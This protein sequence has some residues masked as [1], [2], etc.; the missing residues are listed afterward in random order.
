LGISP[1]LWKTRAGWGGW[2]AY[3]RATPSLRHAILPSAFFI[4]IVAE[5]SS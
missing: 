4:L 3:G 2:R 5:F 1:S